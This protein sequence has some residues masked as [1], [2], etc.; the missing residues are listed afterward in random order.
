M[1]I[2]FRS[3]SG[4]TNQPALLGSR[5]MSLSFLGFF[6][7][8]IHLPFHYGVVSTI[9][10]I[11]PVK[12]CLGRTMLG[13][14]WRR[15]NAFSKGSIWVWCGRVSIC[16]SL[17]IWLSVDCRSRGRGM[18]VARA[19]SRSRTGREI[20][21]PVARRRVLYRHSWLTSPYRHVCNCVAL[22]GVDIGIQRTYA[23]VVRFELTT[24]GFGDRC[25]GH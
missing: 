18:V 5:P 9:D 25:S 4:G 3:H 12:E 19:A 8:A 23:R 24:H 20:R 10:R 6:S 17:G 7:S 21:T 14:R 15:Y 13:R 2:S 22:F 16:R 11:G 1:L